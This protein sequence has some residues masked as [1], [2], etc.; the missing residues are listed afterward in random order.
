M[1]NGPIFWPDR[2]GRNP[3]TAFCT[4]QKLWTSIPR[5]S[6]SINDPRKNIVTFAPL[7]PQQWYARPRQIWIG[8]VPSDLTPSHTDIVLLQTNRQNEFVD[9]TPRFRSTPATAKLTD[10]NSEG[11]QLFRKASQQDAHS[12]PSL[13]SVIYTH[14][15]FDAAIGR[16]GNHRLATNN[17]M[18]DMTTED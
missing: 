1:A 17:R 8:F 10:S 3:P 16:A 15:T 7:T 2:R 14:R 6:D 4:R 5:R 11:N 18:G 12:V 9:P 13:W